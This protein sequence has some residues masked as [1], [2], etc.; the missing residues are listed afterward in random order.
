MNIITTVKSLKTKTLLR[1]YNRLTGKKTTKFAS[2]AK[3]EGQVIGAAKV[4]GQETVTNY[5]RELG[6]PVEV[7]PYTP[8]DPNAKPARK[9]RGT[10]LLPPG[11]APIACREAS[12]QAILLDMLSQHNGA[13]MPELIKAL[14]GGRKPWQEQTVRAGFGWDM[15]QKGYGVRSTFD[16]DGTERFF[17]VKPKMPDGQEYLIPFH[18]P[19]KK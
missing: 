8:K 3:G 9:R 19:L 15:K 5:L 7:N 4:A 10:N 17:I 16:P 12:K 1:L 14:S 18:R 11:G 2:R 13:T 6:V